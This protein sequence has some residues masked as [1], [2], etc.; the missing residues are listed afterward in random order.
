MRIRVN[1]FNSF[2]ERLLFEILFQGVV[3]ITF[4][5]GLAYCVDKY[6]KTSLV[7]VPAFGVLGFLFIFFK[8]FN[9]AIL[10]VKP[11]CLLIK[12]NQW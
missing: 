8:L 6:P 1:S 12:K 9:N 10:Y 4:I 11:E 5:I 3:F 2:W 7:A